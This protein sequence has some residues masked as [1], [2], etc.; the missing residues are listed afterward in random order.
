MKPHPKP[1]INFLPN[2]KKSSH[3]TFPIVVVNGL[4]SSGKSLL[5]P[6]LN[7]F[8][9]LQ[10]VQYDYHVE[11]YTIL[12]AFN[13]LDDKSFRT[14]I[15]LHLDETYY[16]NEIGRKLNFRWKDDSSVQ[17]TGRLLQS[18]KSLKSPEGDN[19]FLEAQAAGRALFMMTHNLFG[20]RDNLATALE[21]RLKFIEIIDDPWTLLPKWCSYLERFD[22]V[23]EATLSF[24]LEKYKVPWFAWDFKNSYKHLSIPDKAACSILQLLPPIMDFLESKDFRNESCLVVFTDSL[25]YSPH[26]EIEK[27]SNFFGDYPDKSLGR[28]F[29]RLDLPRKKLKE[30]DFKISRGGQLRSANSSHAMNQLS[31]KIKDAF[32]ALAERFQNNWDKSSGKTLFKM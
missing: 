23:R 11:Y 5:I 8:K 9:F 28:V 22:G 25:R 30:T 12:R 21:N 4:W 15:N 20:I 29:K 10:S 14:M 24:E 27:I 19:R 26:Q 7:S 17:K 1:N 2:W 6:V 13:S 18:L 3:G 31:P 16:S 32:Y